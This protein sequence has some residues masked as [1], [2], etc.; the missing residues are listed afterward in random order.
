MEIA[1]V[2]RRAAP[3]AEE[4]KMNLRRVLHAV[5]GG[6]VLVVGAVLLVL[7]GPGLL[8]VFAGLVL[9]SRAFPR[10]ER[11]VAPVRARATQAAEISVRSRRRLAGSGL[12]GLALIAAGV[13]WGLRPDLPVGGWATGASLILSG[14]VLLGLLGYSRRQLRDRQEAAAAR[15]S[16]R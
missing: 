9:L 11:F 15:E 14:L 8:L 16:G 4:R 7:P 10:L 2:Q 6:V 3:G 1:A 13:V 5:L 12:V